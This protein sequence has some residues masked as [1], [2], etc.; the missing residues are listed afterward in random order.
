[1]SVENGKV[2]CNCRHNSRVRTIHNRVICVCDISDTYLGDMKV[3]EHWC[4]HWATDEKLWKER[5][6]NETD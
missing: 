2:C 4:R 3:M 1:M 5:L 6:K